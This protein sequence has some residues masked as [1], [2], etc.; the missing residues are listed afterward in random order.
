M[1]SISFFNN[2]FSGSGLSGSGSGND[3]S[4]SSD[5]SEFS[6]SRDLSGSGNDMSGNDMSN[7]SGSGNDMNDSGSGSGNCN[8]SWVVIIIFMAPFILGLFI[9]F[10][11][12]SYNIINYTKN[13]IIK[14]CRS[15]RESKNNPIVKQKLNKKFITTLNTE[16]HTKINKTDELECSICIEPIELDKFK[17]TKNKLVFLNCGHVYHTPCIQGW[18]KSQIKQINKPNCPLC[19]DIIVNYSENVKTVT[20]D[21]DASDASEASY[22][23]D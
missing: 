11:N 1:P 20:Y 2:D 22:W 9:C 15:I 8:G 17:L 21:S 12:N 16:N 10:V 14:K 23:N 3:W 7:L 4:G 18:V 6:G 13:K 5:L 19:R